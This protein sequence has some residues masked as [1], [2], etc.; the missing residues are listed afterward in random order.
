MNIIHRDLK[1]ENIL[2]TNKDGDDKDLLYVKI[3][4]FGTAKIFKENQ[5]ENLIIGSPFYIAPEVI[6]KQY[7]EKCDL[8]SCGVLLYIFLSTK[9]PFNG[10]TNKEI[11]EKIKLGEYDLNM[12]PWNTI[13]KNAK[14]LISKL[15]EIDIKKRISAEDALKHNWFK[16]NKSKELFNNIENKVIT[17]KL[18]NNLI[19]Y[20]SIS[21]IQETALAYLV[22]NFNQTKSVIDACKLFNIIDIDG[23]GKINEKD[24]FDGLKKIIKRKCLENDCKEI[25]NNIDMNHNGFLEYEEFVRAAVDKKEFFNEQFLRF[26]FNYFDKDKDDTIDYNEIEMV[27]KDNIVDRKNIH[28]GLQKI[29]TEV[30]INKDGKITFDEFCSVMK[31]MLI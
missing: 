12:S 25:F 24:L 7:T 13:S 2:I 17:E 9:V 3:A 22:H 19:N 27:F 23:D 8:W 10:K 29:I 21:V 28:E 18:V 11:F 20:K 31:K 26:A 4:D 6:D 1:P 16:E 30:D 15:L 14:D 5:N